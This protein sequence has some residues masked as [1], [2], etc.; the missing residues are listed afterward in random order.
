MAGTKTCSSDLNPP[1]GN[2][3]DETVSRSCARFFNC[4]AIRHWLGILWWSVRF[5]VS[6]IWGSEAISRGRNA[7]SDN[8]RAQHSGNKSIPEETTLSGFDVKFVSATADLSI[9][10]LGVFRDQT[11]TTPG[12]TQAP[13]RRG[14][15]TGLRVCHPSSLPAR[16]IDQ[17]HVGVLSNS[18]EQ[19]P[20]AIGR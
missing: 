13:S 11:A 16:Q 7:V 1:C 4:H 10:G 12:A 6:S 2:R 5:W 3:T 19:N 18:I 8:R 9:S 14:S 20:F 15:S 17:H